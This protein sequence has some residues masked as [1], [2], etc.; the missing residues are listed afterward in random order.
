MVTQC[1]VTHEADI[2]TNLSAFV[3]PVPALSRLSV[4]CCYIQTLFTIY[5]TSAVNHL[6]III[7]I[8]HFIYQG[9]EGE[10]SN[11]PASR[12]LKQDL[13]NPLKI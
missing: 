11:S 4:C 8:F 13:Y 1:H 3:S 12:R 2:N 5:I 6:I 10:A 7:R 9:V